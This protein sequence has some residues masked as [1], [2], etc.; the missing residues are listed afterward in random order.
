MCYRY[1][2]CSPA[3]SQRAGKNINCDHISIEKCHPINYLQIKVCKKSYRVYS[4]HPSDAGWSSLVAR[5]AHNPKVVGSN[6]APA[7]NVVQALL[8]FAVD[9]LFTLRCSGVDVNHRLFNSS[10]RCNRP[11]NDKCS[12]TDTVTVLSR[13]ARGGAAW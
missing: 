11:I 2:H 13:Q 7:T 10:C 5:R 1:P 6:P 4:A 12:A 3:V 8:A 9:W